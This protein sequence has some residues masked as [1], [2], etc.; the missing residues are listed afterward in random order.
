MTRLDQLGEFGLIDLL[1]K[2]VSGNSSVLVGIGDDCAVV[3]E[4]KK[5]HLFTCDA[6]I[7]NIH[8]RRAWASP[9][10]IGRKTAAAA[11][12]DIAAMGGIARY[13]LVTLACARDTD[14]TYLERIYTGL[15]A[16]SE[17]GRVA[18]IG[19]DT[20]ASCEG[21]MISVTVIG[22]A[23]DNPVLRSGA[24]P[25]DVVA[26]TGYPGCAALGL[27]ALEQ[28]DGSAP[29]ALLHAHLRPR[30][31]LMEGK[32]LGNGEVNAMIDLSDGLVQ[33]LGHIAVRSNVS[34]DIETEKLPFT[35]EQCAYAEKSGVSALQAALCGGEDYELAFTVPPRQVATLLAEFKL[36]FHLP[37]TVIGAVTEGPARVTVDGLPCPHT[38]Y[39]HFQTA[40]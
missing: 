31:K 10:D 16:G 22:K 28:G 19:G 14:V 20:T 32:F 6:F 21:I 40:K 35:P 23:L 33:D 1:T 3:Q 37:V 13:M 17:E 25:G 15:K 2:N 8:F 26:V 29:E 7:E 34:I 9:E 38:G 24:R 4:G 5:Q 27:H 12:S 36:Q 18:L 11:L 30:P 39:N